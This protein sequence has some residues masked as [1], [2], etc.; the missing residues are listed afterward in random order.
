MILFLSFQ[1][2]GIINEIEVPAPT[3][4][5]FET[6]DLDLSA[7]ESDINARFAALTRELNSSGRWEQLKPLATARLEALKF[8]REQ[9]QLQSTENTAGYKRLWENIFIWMNEEEEILAPSFANLS[10]T[11][12]KLFSNSFDLHDRTQRMST[13]RKM[14]EE[15]LEAANFF[16]ATEA[17]LK[18]QGTSRSDHRLAH[19]Q[20]VFAREF[21]LYLQMN[22]L[23]NPDKVV[24]FEAE[25]NRAL[26]NPEISEQSRK[27]ILFYMTEFPF[28]TEN[29]YL[30]LYKFAGDDQPF[31]LQREARRAL[32]TWTHRRGLPA[33]LQNIFIKWP[34]GSY[35]EW[36]LVHAGAPLEPSI[37]KTLRERMSSLHNPQLSI[38]M[39]KA[40]LS[41][42]REPEVSTATLLRLRDSDSMTPGIR[43][44]AAT[45]L[46]RD[47]LDDGL[48]LS[49]MQKLALTKESRALHEILFWCQRQEVVPK[50][51][52]ESLNQISWESSHH[53]EE[54]EI[55]DF[56]NK[57]FRLNLRIKRQTQM[58]CP[59]ALS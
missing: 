41:L 39:A 56:K 6:L 14:L 55:N 57:I 7:K 31:S 10:K 48:S 27:Q 22:S 23:L 13:L 45:T 34:E 50:S 1:A 26:N 12:P 5:A 59:E 21:S 58:L 40:W 38:K 49:V 20:G 54:A 29:S 16:K 15:P 11:F 35:A 33:S 19:T 43:A 37:Q 46:L 4:K 47:G 9:V 17:D 36:C 53:L 51:L 3:H 52:M 44:E 8:A 18:N 2:Q 42:Q 28:Q 25:M 32:Q 30:N 24:A